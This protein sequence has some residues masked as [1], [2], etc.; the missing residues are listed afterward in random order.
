MDE[1]E[2]LQNLQARIVDEETEE[3]RANELRQE[4]FLYLKDSLASFQIA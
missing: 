4:L 3:R 2:K 1:N